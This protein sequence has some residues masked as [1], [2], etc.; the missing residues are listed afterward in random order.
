MGSTFGCCGLTCPTCPAC[1]NQ[2]FRPLS[3]IACCTECGF[4]VYR[5]R[6][7]FLRSKMNCSCIW[8][9]ISLNSELHSC[10]C[11][12][13]TL[14]KGLGLACMGNTRGGTRTPNLLLRREAPYP[15]GHTSLTSSIRNAI[16]WDFRHTLISQVPAGTCNLLRL[17][18]TK[19]KHYRFGSWAS[20][21]H[22][23][24]VWAHHGCCH[25]WGLAH[26]GMGCYRM[27]GRINR[28]LQFICA[29]GRCGDT[30]SGECALLSEATRKVHI[31]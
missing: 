5:S 1:W 6:K 4:Q 22:Q 9:Q 27:C 19:S 12:V 25:F 8:D 20:H 16:C 21:S 3:H 23:H 30:Y 10:P 13:R 31:E 24:A 11:G 29:H 18:T 17:C 2:H 26:C 14:D 28:I 15:L 7:T